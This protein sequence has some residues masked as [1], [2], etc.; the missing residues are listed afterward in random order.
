MGGNAP[1]LDCLVNTQQVRV[2]QLISVESTP[3]S[4]G[5]IEQAAEKTWPKTHNE[6]PSSTPRPSETAGARGTPRRP[7]REP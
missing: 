5:R 6:S 4:R 3:S 1:D 2:R 7:R